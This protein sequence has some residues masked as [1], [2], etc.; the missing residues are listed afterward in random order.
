MGK[1]TFLRLAAILALTCL[2]AGRIASAEP[3]LRVSEPDRVAFAIA[4]MTLDANALG[5]TDTRFAT[6]LRKNL[7]D[8]GLDARPADRLADDGI[9]FLDL[10]VEDDS[11][12]ASLEFWRKAAYELPDG[13]FHADHVVVWEE[14]CVGSHLNDPDL[15]TRSVERIIDQFVSAYRQS[16]EQRLSARL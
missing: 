12:V 8:A 15:V 14:Y 3:G 9:L 13:T 1:G 4:N 6:A 7:V 5:L 11:F 16:N 2:L 10:V